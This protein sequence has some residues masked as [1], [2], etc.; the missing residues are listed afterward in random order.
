M[1]DCIKCGEQ[2]SWCKCEEGYDNGWSLEKEVGYKLGDKWKYIYLPNICLALLPLVAAFWLG[3]KLITEPN[4][5][6][7][8]NDGPMGIMASE[9]M[10]DAAPGVAQWND[11][12]WLGSNG[13]VFEFSPSY[14]II[15]CLRGYNWMLV[16]SVLF[17]GWSLKR[18][19]RG[20]IK[21]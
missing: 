8:S 15:W 6:L 19:I 13:R 3:G 2:P 5:I 17:L 14:V 20:G 7:F 12:N 1:R 18:L 4:T 11:M 16:P 21:S 10:I 9:F